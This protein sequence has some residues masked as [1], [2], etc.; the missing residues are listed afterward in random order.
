MLLGVKQKFTFSVCSA[1][2]QNN[3]FRTC[4]VIIS[5]PLCLNY[6]SNV[7]RT[8]RQRFSLKAM[9]YRITWALHSD[10]IPTDIVGPRTS[11][12]FYYW[13]VVTRLSKFQTA[14]LSCLFLSWSSMQPLFGFLSHSIKGCFFTRMWYSQIYISAVCTE[15]SSDDSLPGT[16]MH[17][18]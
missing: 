10:D 16:D 7:P 1:A 12:V 14:N 2:G 5:L 8:Y 4:G 6:S 11:T 9:L 17:K 13:P 15:G 18:N 3:P